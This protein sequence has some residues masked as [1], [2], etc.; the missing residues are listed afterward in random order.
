[1]GG[2]GGEGGGGMRGGW[3]WNDEGVRV[4]GRDLYS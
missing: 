2:R 3:G 4:E 1:M